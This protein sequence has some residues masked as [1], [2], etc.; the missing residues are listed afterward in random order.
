MVWQ[1]T[2]RRDKRLGQGGK[3]SWP[4]RWGN[5]CRFRQGEGGGGSVRQRSKPWRTV[6]Y[7]KSVRTT[8]L[9]ILGNRGTGERNELLVYEEGE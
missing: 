8:L 7:S 2:D 4:R 6:G 9:V 1:G 5:T 3:V